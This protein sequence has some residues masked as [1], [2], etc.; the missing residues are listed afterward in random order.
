MS[1]NISLSTGHVH[2]HGGAGLMRAC[3]Y[4]GVRKDLLVE[5]VPVPEIGAGDALV[6]VVASGIC[7]SDWHLWN[8]DLA[9][10][11]LDMP[12][13]TTLGHEIG[14]V[15]ERVGSGVRHVE[16][17]MRV[18]IPFNLACGFCQYC[19]AGAQH[20]CDNQQFPFLVEGGGGWQQFI[21]VP[22]AD[23]N[24]IPLPDG[25]DELTAAALGCRYMTAWRAVADRANVAGGEFVVVHG[26]GG[27]GLAAVQIS[28][29]LG[30]RTIAVDIDDQKLATARAAGAFA[31]LN[32]KGMDPT[33]V[34]AAI[35]DMSGGSGAEVAIDALGGTA[36]TLGALYSLRKGGRLAQVGMTGRA[37]QGIV[38]VPL[39][40]LVL[41]ELSIIGS[42]G[43]PQSGYP[44]LLGLVASGRLNPTALVSRHVGL[45]EVQ[46]VL[47]DMD[48]FKTTGYVIITRF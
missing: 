13:P 16:P 17:G 30:G 29:A 12:A 44:R 23:V 3:R 9:W 8:G 45:E 28:A 15:I 4:Q 35:K 10:L 27:V 43:N 26:C 6:R 34:G 1:A 42:Q 36:T 19:R 33:E 14:G 47:E 24:C 21:R 2:D 39:D 40:L 38:G 22:T 7:R 37:E 20:L 48:E 46:G 41:Q 18:T 11:G 25:V 32:V 5:E 31:T